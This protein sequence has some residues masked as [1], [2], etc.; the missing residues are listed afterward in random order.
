MTLKP[1]MTKR[2]VTAADADAFIRALHADGK[3]YHFDDNPDDIVFD[4]TGAPVFECDEVPALRGRV[5]EMFAID[6]YDP[7]ALAVQLTN[8]DWES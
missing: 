7:F 2:I 8:E 5:G 3:L 1:Y 4:A 6:G